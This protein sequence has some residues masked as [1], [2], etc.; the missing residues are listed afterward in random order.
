MARDNRIGYP[1]PT[2][3]LADGAGWGAAEARAEAA[4]LEVLLA[5][6]A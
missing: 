1:D 2:A 6:P 4:L 5:L 3:W